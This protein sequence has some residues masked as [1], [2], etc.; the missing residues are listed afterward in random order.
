[1][2]RRN[3]AGSSGVVIDHCRQHGLWFDLHELEHIQRFVADGGIERARSR[4]AERDAAR[5]RGSKPTVAIPVGRPGGRGRWHSTDGTIFF[6]ALGA[7]LGA[8]V[9]GLFD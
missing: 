2:N 1:M 5:A 4:R 8:L 6:E 9:E 3:F 7:F